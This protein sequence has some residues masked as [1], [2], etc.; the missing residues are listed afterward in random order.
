MVFVSMVCLVIMY[1]LFYQVRMSNLST[2]V[3]SLTVWFLTCNCLCELSGPSSVWSVSKGTC[4][5]AA[6]TLLEAAADWHE[7]MNDA[8][9]GVLEDCPKP[10]GQLED[11]WRHGRGCR[12]QLPPPLNFGLLENCLKISVS[13]NFWL[14]Y[15]TDIITS[16]LHIVLTQRWLLWKVRNE[17]K[18]SPCCVFC[19][20]N[21]HLWNAG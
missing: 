2:L 1:L 7:L 20:Q 16:S 3:D 9:D 11:Q 18:I 17:E 13:E 19:E 4:Y 12:G 21:I 6:Y 8:R 10:W 15:W 5:N 14:F